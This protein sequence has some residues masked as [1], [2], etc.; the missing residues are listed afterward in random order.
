MNENRIDQMIAVI[1]SS[2]PYQL[3]FQWIESMTVGYLDFP[4][5][6]ESKVS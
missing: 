3:M 2:R 1:Q 6:I 5:D 4:G